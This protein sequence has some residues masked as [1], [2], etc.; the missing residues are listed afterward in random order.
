MSDKEFTQ[1]TLPTLPSS[2]KIP[3]RFQVD[4][5]SQQ[6]QC[7]TEDAQKS[8]HSNFL[9]ETLQTRMAMNNLQEQEPETPV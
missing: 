1:L 4:E 6:E 9:V 3:F 7:L 8:Q 2:N 5:K